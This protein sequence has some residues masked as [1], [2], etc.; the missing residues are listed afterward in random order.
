MGWEP[1]YKSWVPTLPKTLTPDDLEEIN[2][3]FMWIVNPALK[4]LRKKCSEISPT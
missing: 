1:L 4:Y 2:M 3:L